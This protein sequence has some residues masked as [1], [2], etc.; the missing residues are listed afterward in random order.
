MKKHIILIFAILILAIVLSKAKKQEIKIIDTNYTQIQTTQIVLAVN[1]ETEVIHIKYT[2]YDKL[3]ESQK[4][5]L[6]GII[7]AAAGSESYRGKYLVACV[8]RNRVKKYG[9]Y[10]VLTSG[11]V[12]K[13]FYITDETGWELEQREKQ[14]A[15]A[16]KA[17]ET[18]FNNN[19]YP[20]LMYYQNPLYSTDDGLAFF[21]NLEYVLSEGGHKFYKEG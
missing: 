18:A 13:P 4:G 14:L 17:L 8:L 3:T 9:I 10:E 19:A 21:N 6:T 20:E 7:M 16:E 12:E 15:D 11:H 5:K 2:L 1:K